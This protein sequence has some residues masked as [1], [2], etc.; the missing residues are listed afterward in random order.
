MAS[1]YRAGSVSFTPL[2]VWSPAETRML[3]TSARNPAHCG[4]PALVPPSCVH[5]WLA[6]ST[7]L[8]MSVLVVLK[9]GTP[10]AGSALYDTSGVERNAVFDTAAWYAGVASNMLSPPCEPIQTPSFA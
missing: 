5:P 6:G 4:E 9:I 1:W 7:G 10:V 2:S 3:L 8:R